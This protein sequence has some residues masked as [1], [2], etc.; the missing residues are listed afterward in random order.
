MLLVFGRW[1]RYIVFLANKQPVLAFLAFSL[2]AGGFSFILFRGSNES[3]LQ[4][5]NEIINQLKYELKET[6]ELQNKKDSVHAVQIFLMNKEIFAIQQKAND[7]VNNFLRRVTEE[8]ARTNRD[9]QSVRSFREKII[10]K[11]KRIIDKNNQI[12]NKLENAD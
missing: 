5:K 6:R 8:Q 7:E 9:Q 10:K 4:E 2:L 12:S 3:R 1:I 11:N